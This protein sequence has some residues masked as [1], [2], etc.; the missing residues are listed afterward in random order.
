MKNS[1]IILI[2]LLFISPKIFCQTQSCPVN[3]NFVL[4]NLTHWEAYTG[5][6][7]NG[8]NDQTRFYYDSTKIAPGGTINVKTIAEYNLPSVTGIQIITAQGNDFFGG[9][10]KIPTINGYAYNYSILL[11]STSITHST[12]GANAGGYVRGVSYQITVPAT[13]LGQPYTMTYAY[14]MVLE[15]G[16]HASD[17]Q[18]LFSATL[19]LANGA[20]ISC[21]SPKYFLPTIP[22][23]VNAGNG[24][25]ELDSATAKAEGFTV[26]SQL[27]PNVD[28]NGG[29]GT[30]EHLQD[31]WTKGWNEVTFDLSPYR[32]QK[33]TL[34]FETDNCVPGG[35]FAYS[36]VALR[37]TCAGLNISGPLVACSNTNFTYSVPALLGASY[38]WTVP[39]S[40]TI[41]SGS[42]TNI[43]NVSTG[44]TGGA[45]IAN[46]VNSCAN[47]K[48]TIQVS[49]SPPT[50]PGNVANDATVCANSNGSTLL[51]S[52]NRGNVISWIS[53]TNGTNW[54][55]IPDTTSSYTYTNLNATTVFEALVQNGTTCRIDSSLAATITINQKTLG[56]VLDPANTDFCADQTVADVLTLNNFKGQITNWQSS[57]DSVNWQN[58]A[59]VNNDS[60]YNVLGLGAT[61]YFRSIVKNGDCP[62]D[63]SAVASV[64]LFTTPFPQSVFDPADT[65]I[66]YGTAAPLN[67]V[68]T[69]GT[70]YTWIKTD[71]LQNPGN[72]VISSSPFSLTS[73]AYPSGTTN[74]V[75]SIEN[76]GCPN[77]LLDTFHINVI[78]QIILNA[79]NDTSVVVGEPLQLHATSNDTTED[80]FTWTPP[81][82]LSS[83]NTSSPIGIYGSNI[84]TITYIVK[85]TDAYGCY[86]VNKISVRVFKTVPDIF[87]PNAFTPGKGINNIFRPIAAGISSLKYFRVYNRW[88]QLVYATEQIEQ[89]WDGS[90]GGKQQDSGTFVWMVQGIDYTGRTITK[91]GTMVLIR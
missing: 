73:Q 28:P 4:D 79:G 91:K 6:N 9:F 8:N 89:G 18:P 19:T 13:P 83:P 68:I 48:D 3:I 54:T 5:N 35:H 29:P 12:G 61:T 24:Q 33:V 23:T 56:G 1:L 22:G 50:I 25:G 38:N 42:G 27:S 34:T 71:S 78:P 37:N 43:I 76:N 53:S 15:N 7:A 77:Y 30:T 20:I 45:V 88:G 80:N 67:S 75:L 44:A 46:E 84:D 49:T 62:A 60:T 63:T 40:W 17:D 55:A 58:F 59:P 81:T 14:A 11:G 72:G 26:S 36:Y 87:V 10:Q 74:Y 31:V 90:V 52:G 47:L 21:A 51:L 65:T 70:N 86:G 32:G 82:D 2:G 64:K 16:R 41:N 57:S 69:I 39:G 66:C 85:A